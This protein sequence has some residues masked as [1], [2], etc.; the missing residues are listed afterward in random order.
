M[1][2][3]GGA[4]DGEQLPLRIGSRDDGF[5]G[6]VAV[7]TGSAGNRSYLT[8]V[9]GTGKLLRNFGQSL[10]IDDACRTFRDGVGRNWTPFADGVRTITSIGEGPSD[11][12]RLL[13]QQRLCTVDGGALGVIELILCLADLDPAAP[14]WSGSWDLSGPLQNHAGS[15][16]MWGPFVLLADELLSISTSAA[17]VKVRLG[18]PA[19]DRFLPPIDA[20]G[21]ILLD[22]QIGIHGWGLA[23]GANPLF[24]WRMEKVP[25]ADPSVASVSG[26]LVADGPR[27]VVKVNRISLHT[28]L[29]EVVLPCKEVE[30]NYYFEDGVCKA[31][32]AKI[33]V[34]ASTGLEAH[35]ILHYRFCANAQQSAGWRIVASPSG[36]PSLSWKSGPAGELVL[37]LGVGKA[38][39]ISFTDVS[40]RA[41]ELEQAQAGAQ[42]WLVLGK[43]TGG[44]QMAGCLECRNGDPDQATQLRLAYSW[45]DLLAKPEA[46]FGS[47]DEVSRI[48]VNGLADW[49][50]R[51]WE[52]APATVTRTLSGH[53]VLDNDYEFEFQQ[54]A[55]APMTMRDCVHCFFDGVP[56]DADGSVAGDVL[57]AMVEHRL[58]IGTAATPVFSFQVPQAIRLVKFHD[59]KVGMVA[60][61][62]I[63]LRLTDAEADAPQVVPQVLYEC[64]EALSACHGAASGNGHVRG[65]LLRLPLRT[66][67]GRSVLRVPLPQLPK[68]EWFP[69]I[70]PPVDESCAPASRWQERRALAHALNAHTIARLCES[71]T[72]A[73]F[74]TGVGLPGDGETLPE[75][76]AVAQAVGW[77]DSG[78]LSAGVGVLATPYY[79]G[80]LKRGVYPVMESAI[81]ATL[82][83][84]DAA[85]QG[86]L[87]EVAHAL[88]TDAAINGKDGAPDAERTALLTWGTRE[89]LRRSLR[90]SALVMAHG[91]PT[92]SGPVP[93]SF[94]VTAVDD[95]ASAPPLLSGAHQPRYSALIELMRP[96]EAPAMASQVLTARTDQDG[97]L[98][99]VDAQPLIAEGEPALRFRLALNH[100][101]DNAGRLA[102]LSSIGAALSKRQ[103]IMFAESVQSDARLR[104]VLPLVSPLAGASAQ[105][106]SPALVDVC[107]AVLRPG[108]MVLTRWALRGEGAETGPGVELGLRSA[109]AGNAAAGNAVALGIT[110]RAKALVDG[111]EWVLQEVTTARSLGAVPTPLADKGI[112]VTVVTPRDTVHR[113][114][115]F[116]ADP[117]DNWKLV[118]GVAAQQADDPDSTEGTRDLSL[119]LLE[120]L[121]CGAFPH[122]VGALVSEGAELAWAVAAGDQGRGS[123]DSLDPA[124][125]S[126]VEEID[127]SARARDTWNAAEQI[128]AVRLGPWQSMMDRPLHEEAS[129]N[130]GRYSMAPGADL[131]RLLQ[132]TRKDRNASRH[133]LLKEGLE[134][135]PLLVLLIRSGGEMRY[136]VAFAVDWQR[137]TALEQP[138]RVL[139]VHG[140]RVIGFGDLAGPQSIRLE[141]DA[142]MLYS[143]AYALSLALPKQE[144]APA[145]AWLFNRDGA[146]GAITPSTSP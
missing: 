62:V 100:I 68:L 71:Q 82:Y 31:L 67:Q 20:S 108:D 73:E 11:P 13:T 92:L 95:E 27:M 6:P 118:L 2:A 81:P 42:R 66:G 83:V 29:G 47:L 137:G 109:R 52:G 79:V 50:S 114:I 94:V 130:P 84:P 125:V 80:V 54:R 19:G 8:R 131:G 24:E 102:P 74:A 134:A 10:W 121:L 126:S 88:V 55:A 45:T 138:E 135:G 65:L 104:R 76:S 103:R 101:V 98:E 96:A 133:W 87:R 39:A 117:Q 56:L 93:R 143:T 22:W 5:S 111:V 1:Q 99:V 36:E 78:L 123:R 77:L 124:E 44:K 127:A 129:T 30:L 21:A 23:L 146:C 58:H 43:C 32:A 46:C 105:I 53:L 75:W 85:V 3:T 38:G 69:L 140:G 120:P 116:G 119:R 12:R 16:P 72:A 14:E 7:V 128:R 37:E 86:G 59:G 33:E 41:L 48:R 90:S 60:N 15:T 97:V 136:I 64:D 63:L 49:C 17:A 106:V 40:G 51:H 115:P 35:F 9:M 4:D 132:L 25:S 110:E 57:H 107:A 70:S 144:S 122:E 18:A 26:T 145:R 141:H 89:L 28:S 112:E 61:D 142:F 34:E 113:L 139:A 91:R